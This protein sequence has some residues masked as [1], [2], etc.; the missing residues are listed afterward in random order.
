MGSVVNLIQGLVRRASDFKLDQDDAVVAMQALLSFNNENGCN[1]PVEKKRIISHFQNIE[2][3]KHAQL[4]GEKRLDALLAAIPRPAH[5]PRP[6]NVHSD[7]SATP[8][9]PL[10]S[11]SRR[12]APLPAS[13]ASKQAAPTSSSLPSPRSPRRGDM[14][15]DID[16]AE[17]SSSP[18]DSSQK[19]GHAVR[20]SRTQ[21][22]HKDSCW[23]RAHPN[24]I[25]FHG[26]LHRA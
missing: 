9:P 18:P 8:A 3:T 16:P 5:P 1:S 2:K 14:A 24:D 11:T 23:V 19:L 25:T 20:A 4:E 7:S 15:K 12:P 17:P 6:T 21:E 13:L 22:H 10:Q 26:Y